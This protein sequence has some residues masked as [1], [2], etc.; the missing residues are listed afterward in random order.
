M[1]NCSKLAS[2]LMHSRTQ[3]HVFHL[4]T[5]S[6]AEHKALNDY[7]DGIVDLV[8]GFVE[9]YQGKYGIINNY[10]SFSL[11]NYT[12]KQ[13]VIQYFE[14]LCMTVNTLR[15][16]ITDSYLDNQVD[17]MVALINSTLYKLKCL[18]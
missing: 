9:S 6:F 16:D 17:E 8:D 5:T 3:A 1:E 13:Q 12:N 10:V 4:Q 11:M 7:Y 15:Q 18:N 2:Y 14:A